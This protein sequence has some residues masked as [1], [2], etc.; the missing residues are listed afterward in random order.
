[1]PPQLLHAPA[2]QPFKVSGES[3]ETVM[4]RRKSND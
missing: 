4:E 2:L 3:V 1:M